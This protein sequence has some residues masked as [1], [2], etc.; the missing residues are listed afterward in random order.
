M[1]S[2]D[3]FQAKTLAK[4]FLLNCL[5]GACDRV[6]A[7]VLVRVL[8]EGVDEGDGASDDAHVLVIEEMDDAQQAQRGGEWTSRETLQYVGG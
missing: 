1:E 3:V 4:M 6:A 5:P 2:Q 8:L 7:L